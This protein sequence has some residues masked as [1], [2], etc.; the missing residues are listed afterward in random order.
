VSRA[1]RIATLLVACAA[2]A[3]GDRTTLPEARPESRG[4]EARPATA[5]TNSAPEKEPKERLASIR[6]EVDQLLTA[7]A[8]LLWEAW[9]RGASPD[10]DAS[11]AGREA[12]FSRETL[13]FVKDARDRAEGDERRALALLHAFLVG[14]H[15]AREA[16][17]VSQ[18]A[19]GR[20][21][22]TWDGRTVPIERVPA[23][24]ALEPDP[25]RRA[26]L[27]R[28]W[29]DAE[30]RH[31]AVADARWRGIT[32]A[33]GRIGYGSPLALAVELR[34]EPIRDL[35]ALA[36]SVLAETDAE[37]R[38]IVD[39]LAH[40]EMG[41]GLAQLR[42]RDMPR[43]LRAGEDARAF[44]AGRATG[45]VGKTLAALGLDLPGRPG[46][47]LDL[48][49]RSGKDPRALALPVEVPGSVRV[50]FAPQGGA[51]ELRALLHEMGVATYYAYVATPVLEFRRLGAVTSEAWAGLFEDLASDPRWLAERTGLAENHLA[52]IVRAAAARRLHQAR[53]LAARVLVEIGRA[54]KP[55]GNPAVAKAILERA[56]A[57][58]VEADE[59]GLFLLE[60]DP[61]LESADALR[62]LLLA[63]QGEA[64]L[65]GRSRTS[66]WGSKESGAW[67]AAAFA[68]GSR[69]APA[70][71]A[72]SFGAARVDASALVASS[73]ARA[74]AAGIRQAVREGPSS[75]R[76]LQPEAVT[77]IALKRA[78][79]RP[80]DLADVEALEAIAA[81]EGR[82]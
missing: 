32:A 11:L 73:R 68:D 47:V 33:A 61:L 49:A 7:Q 66:W 29:A 19:A 77:L 45:D 53:T 28:A 15:L 59:L 9:T 57:R 8:K 38:A 3:H 81:R 51:A 21:T 22:L 39:A 67:L 6:A 70:D 75:P 71:L 36:N 5:A 2:C 55:G 82:R 62:A 46:V 14:E 27:E 74:A 52:P 80:L 58:P 40:V 25:A 17:A 34:G 76:S 10:L 78:A 20:P 63:A 44:P 4:G 16:T 37:Y 18:A 50:S 41:A 65:A 35:G 13:A 79:G 43:L 69:L 56:F 42:G 1:S 30:R 72:R 24:L 31:A 23:L 48:E 64:F 26:G 12:L 54:A 60:R